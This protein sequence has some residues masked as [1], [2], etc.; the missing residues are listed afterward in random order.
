MKNDIKKQYNNFASLF[1][2]M[3]ADYDNQDTALNNSTSQKEFYSMIDF[4]T[5]ESKVLDLGCGDGFDV[6]NYKKITPNIFGLDAS[7]EMVKLAKESNPE[8]IIKIGTFENTGFEDGYFDVVLSKYAI[9]TAENIQPV[10][11]EIYRILKKNGFFMFLVVHPTRHYFEKQNKNADYFKQEI[12]NSRIFKETIV[13]QEPTHT[14]N[15]YLNKDFLSKFD[16][17]NFKESFDPSAEQIE[18]RT[19]P[20]YFIVVCR[21]R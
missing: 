7:D 1:S 2:K 6:S 19:Y 13:L 4:I 18:S 14:F 15:E 8:T 17:I 3:S 21:K 10:H 9:Q 5:P 12:V 16:V 11:D 20:G